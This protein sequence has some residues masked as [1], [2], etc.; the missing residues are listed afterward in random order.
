MDNETK[1][2]KKRFNIFDSQ[3]EGKGV[4]KGEVKTPNFKNFFIYFGRS[5]T[6]LLNV[7]LMF[8]FFCL[9]LFFALL[10]GTRWF[11]A[12]VQNVTHPLAS[13]LNGLLTAGEYT[14][15]TMSLYGVYG[16]RSGVISQ[17]SV[18][19]AILYGLSF[20][21]VLTW[22]YANCGLAYTLRNMQRG[23]PVFVWSD[24]FRTAKKNAGQGL[25][26]GIID[27]AVFA[28]MYYDIRV[29]SYNASN[30]V[31]SFMYIIMLFLFA[32]YCVMRM[33]I[34]LMLVTFDLKTFKLFKN[35]FI[36]VFAGLG[37]NVLGL[38]GVIAAVLL[39][40]VIFWTF[41]PLGIILPFVLTIGVIG[42]IGVY[43]AYPKIKE[44]MIDPYQA[45]NGGDPDGEEPED[46][47]SGEVSGAVSE[48]VT[49]E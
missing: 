14:P 39:N 46:G 29:Y 15:V 45:E 8:T 22:G 47:F 49:E 23:E 31:F 37:R 20:L 25:I 13:A 32:V 6:R 4:E 48:E 16:I 24:F 44:I 36:F 9:P 42:Y 17:L 43:T 30:S 3:R 28:L 41:V 40:M 2:K 33:Y 1:P 12:T 26:V 10:A 7:N 19:S 35:A 38:I 5:F 18:P 27:V 34:Y 11:D 21:T